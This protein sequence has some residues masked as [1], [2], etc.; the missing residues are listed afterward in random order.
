MS[1]F[2]FN[3]TPEGPSAPNASGLPIPDR[4]FELSA[5]AWDALVH[6]QM[7]DPPIGAALERYCRKVL[8]A[9]DTAEGL[10]PKGE[11]VLAARSAA[12]R[13][14]T[15][16]GDPDVRAVLEAAYKVKRE[17]DRLMGLLRF[18]PDGRG[19][20]IAYCAPDHRVLPGLAEYFVR[21]FGAA[22]WAVIDEKRGLVLSCNGSEEPR[23]EP[24]PSAGQ[25]VKQAKQTEQPDQWEA[26]W[27]QYHKI[28]NNEDRKNPD[29]Q[30]QF[31]PKRY[32][33]YLSEMREE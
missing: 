33:K 21:R 13:A 8:A 24:L 3:D 5:D 6:A 28:I 25:P 4:L 9:A 1:D 7:S 20:Y 11:K 12:A 15:D 27:R 32:W 10:G 2:L 26:L 14:A 22:P 17:I 31:M 19:V 16:R 30:R 18:N 29:L 23:M